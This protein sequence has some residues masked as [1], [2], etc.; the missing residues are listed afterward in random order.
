M[1][2]TVIIIMLVVQCPHCT[3]VAHSGLLR[4]LEINMVLYR[5]NGTT[6]AANVSNFIW[7]WRSPTALKG[8]LRQS[9]TGEQLAE[10]VHECNRASGIDYC[11]IARFETV[12]HEQK[13]F[14]NATFQIST[15][16]SAVWTV[17][18]ESLIINARL[19]NVLTVR[20]LLTAA[21]FV[22]FQRHY[23]DTL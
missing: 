22:A 17:R 6:S 8:G 18:N 10:G 21:Y 3:K 12:S 19:L 2:N 13:R 16:A 20:L 23:H 1:H 9:F 7:L 11:F 15:Q 4:S 14:R 5:V